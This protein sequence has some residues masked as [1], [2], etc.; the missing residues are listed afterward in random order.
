MFEWPCSSL[1][2]SGADLNSVREKKKSFAE[3]ESTAA[4]SE[5]SADGGVAGDFS[6]TGI[7]SCNVQV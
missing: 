5:A 3:A 6:I 1:R 4:D 2:Q 7:F